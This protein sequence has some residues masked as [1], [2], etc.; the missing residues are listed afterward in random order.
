MMFVLPIKPIGAYVPEVVL[1]LNFVKSHLKCFCTTPYT[2]FNAPAHTSNPAPNWKCSGLKDISKSAARV[3]LQ[4]L[5]IE[6]WLRSAVAEHINHHM[7]TPN[8][9]LTTVLGK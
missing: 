5:L 3:K 6:W 1:L 7:N 8:I 2:P 4:N 9:K